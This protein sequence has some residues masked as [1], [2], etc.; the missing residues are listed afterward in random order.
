L[1]DAVTRLIGHITQTR[2]EDLPQSALDAARTFVLD[3]LGVA[4]VGSLAPWADRLAAIQARW[5][6]GS[7]A[8]SWVFGAPLPA[9]AAA[10]VNAYQIHNSE[11]DCIHEAAVVHPMAVTFPAL[12]AAAERQRGVNGRD[13]MLALILGV[14]VACHIGVAAQGKMRFFRPA[15]A[16]AF[17]AV[18]AIGKLNGF[19][20]DTLRSAM[21]V[22][23][24]QLCGTM[25]AHHEGSVLLAMQVGFNARNAV[26][27]CD[28]A[29]DGIL[30]PTDMLEGP[31]GY[32]A[33][34]EEG[35]D[36]PGALDALGQDWRITE[37]AHKPFPSG[38]ATHGVIDGLLALQAREDF[39]AADIARVEARVPPLTHQLVGR[40]PQ[41]EMSPNQAR[42][43]ISFA[44]ARALQN[45]TLGV[46]DFQ[47]AALKDAQTLDLARRISVVQDDNPD[48]NALTPVAFKVT[49]RDGQ[50]FDASQSIVYGN[51]QKPMSRTAHL[52]KFHANWHAAAMPPDNANKLVA[53]ID[54]IE[55]VR[56]MA[57]LVD[58]MQR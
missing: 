52:A 1:N 22:V 41:D 58:L 8:R 30:A 34:F 9:P 26:I 46:G 18:A 2:F 4:A 37:V 17:G 14:D 48:P 49:L 39:A 54:D 35:H 11:F 12:L 43:C 27:A 47:P 45:R 24:S 53:M 25:Q 28:M 3:S 16:G 38:R 31:Y 5:G 33:L 56:D 6:S 51:P 55:A 15:L 44:A 57:K 23:Y 32:Y 13:F 20:A 36:L 7:D 21:G 19:D 50:T 40:V 29:A 42:L 10:F